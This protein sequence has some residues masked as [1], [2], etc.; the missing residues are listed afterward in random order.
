M[1]A[2]V[3]A[4][5]LGFKLM[6][7]Y[8]TNLVHLSHDGTTATCNSRFIGDETEAHYADYFGCTRC[9]AKLAK[10]EIEIG[11]SVDLGLDV[12]DGK[13]S[14]ICNLHSTTISANT[15]AEVTGITTKEFCEC[16]NE[17][18]ASRSYTCPNCD[19]GGVI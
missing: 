9:V 10:A 3:K 8:K 13:W 16:C 5:A 2:K 6:H 18:C 17:V 12:T 7:D 11:K 15:K 1:N 4:V 14:A 19:K